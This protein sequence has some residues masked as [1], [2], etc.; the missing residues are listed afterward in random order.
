MLF[1]LRH[2]STTK[3]LGIRNLLKWIK[4]SYG[5][6]PIYI[7]ENGFGDN[8]TLKDTGRVSFYREYIN[9]VMKG[10][11]SKILADSQK[12]YCVVFHL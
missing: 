4:R 11:P 1:Y 3:G 10:K 5:D 9:N 2:R 12:K 7:T 8:G 6:V